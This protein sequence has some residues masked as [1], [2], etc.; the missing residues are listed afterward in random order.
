MGV[1]FNSWS[2]RQGYV[3]IE[4]NR[5]T[6]QMTPMV[7]LVKFDWTE[8]GAPGSTRRMIGNF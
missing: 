8:V 6:N 2:W 1:K 5:L 3:R 4:T 7:G